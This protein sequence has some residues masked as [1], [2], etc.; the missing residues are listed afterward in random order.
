MHILSYKRNKQIF[1][2]GQLCDLFSLSFL[3]TY[4]K[5]QNRPHVERKKKGNWEKKSLLK[6]WHTS[7]CANKSNTEARLNNSQFQSLEIPR[8]TFLNKIKLFF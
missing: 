2:R 1:A 4:K 8:L 7:S 3:Y 5:K 6:L